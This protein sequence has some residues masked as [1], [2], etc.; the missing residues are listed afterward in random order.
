[1][2]ISLIRPYRYATGGGA[3]LPV[4]QSRTTNNS[5]GSRVSSINADY[6]SSIGSGDLLLAGFQGNENRTWNTKTGWTRWDYTNASGLGSALF[7]RIADG[8]ETGSVNF[9]ANGFSRCMC[10]MARITGA[11]SSSPIDVGSKT[12]IT[13]DT[14]TLNA[15][16]ITTTQASTLGFYWLAAYPAGY[17]GWASAAITSGWTEVL[18]TSPHVFYGGAAAWADY[19]VAETKALSISRVQLTGT[20]THAIYWIAIAPE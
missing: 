5:S 9:T 14:A 16:G 6:P 1:M 11:H 2:S 20:Q 19:E 18:D 7:W 4:Y 12:I 15:T 8:T 3:S 17:S 13:S 10:T